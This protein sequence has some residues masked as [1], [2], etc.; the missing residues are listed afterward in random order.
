MLDIDQPGLTQDSAIPKGVRGQQM[1][2]GEERSVLADD[3]KAV[4]DGVAGDP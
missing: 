3:A 1:R 2:G 4:R